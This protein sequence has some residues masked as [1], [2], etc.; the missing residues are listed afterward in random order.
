MLCPPYG[1]AGWGAG[2]R[3]GTGGDWYSDWL[4]VGEREVSD[5]SCYVWWGCVARWACRN[6]VVWSDGVVVVACRLHVPPASQGGAS[7]VI[8]R[9]G[10]GMVVVCS[11][12]ASV[13]VSL[14]CSI[15]AVAL[16]HVL[17]AVSLSAMSSRVVWFIVA[18]RWT[19]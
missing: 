5:S 15:A 1:S 6:K 14:S 4:I 2:G 3:D 11:A 12:V 13:V 19:M 18:S 10:A 17:L 16:S 8:E 7:V 9:E